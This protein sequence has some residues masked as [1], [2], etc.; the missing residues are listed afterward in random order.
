MT[1]NIHNMRVCV[2]V[3][4]TYIYLKVCPECKEQKEKRRKSPPAGGCG[5]SETIFHH[6]WRLTG[7]LPR[8]QRQREHSTER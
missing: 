4:K 5:Q 7:C 8:L 1:Y 6:N 3:C 2:C